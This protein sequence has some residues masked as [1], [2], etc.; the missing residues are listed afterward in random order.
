MQMDWMTIVFIAT[1]GL[2]SALVAFL[3]PKRLRRNGIVP[4]AIFILL[5]VSLGALVKQCVSPAIH[6][7]KSQREIDQSLSQISAYQYIAKYDPKAYQQIRDKILDS[8]KKGESQEQATA[9]GRKVVAVFVSKYI[10]RASDEAVIRYMNAMVQEIEELASKDPEIC[11]QFLFPERY[12]TSDIPQNLK[13]ET[14]RADLAALA[15]VIRTAAE[16]PQPEPDQKKGEESLKRLMNSFYQA[17][18]DEAF[19][20]KD[21]FAPGIDKEKVCRLI[22]SFYK[23]GLNLPKEEA[24]MVL[25]YMLSTRKQ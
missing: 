10:P 7:W 18:G 17:H 2:I 9:R 16:Q 13:P 19:L 4:T 6:L 25:R 20:L 24:G 12:G 22:A 21:P 1:A 14:R 23:E 11:Y 5:F 15:D 8:I 3:T